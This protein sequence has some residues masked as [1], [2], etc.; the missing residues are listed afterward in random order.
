MI[1]L[2]IATTLAAPSD[3]EGGRVVRCD[4]ADEGAK[5]VVRY[6]RVEL[7]PGRRTAEGYLL[8]EATIAKPGVLR[9]LRAD[10]TVVRELVPP[11]ELHKAD[12][13]ATLGRKPVTL[14]HP[15]EGMVTTDNVGDLAVGDID[16]DVTIANDGYVKIKMAVRRQDALDAIAAGTHEMSP[17]YTCRIDA[18]PGKHPIYGEYDAI[19]RERRYNHSAIVKRAR[20]GETIRL[21]ADSAVAVDTMKP[22]AAPATRPVTLPST[23][24]PML[25]W[26]PLLMLATR[27]DAQ[28]TEVRE[29]LVAGGVAKADAD[30]LLT[31]FDAGRDARTELAR[32]DAEAVKARTD[33]ER[34]EVKAAAAKATFDAHM[35][36]FTERAPLVELAEGFKMDAAEVAK[37]DNAALCKAIALKA[38]PKL[39]QDRAD[40]YYASYV[41]IVRNAPAGNPYARL[42]KALEERE[43]TAPADGKREPR[44]NRFDA[45]FDEQDPHK[46][47]ARA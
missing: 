22:Q 19:Q 35:A 37:L 11:E 38:D 9:Y 5:E 28:T 21:R 29:G 17:G 45:A 33:A 47:S 30:K 36:F 1:L 43:D 12:S 8:C 25:R 18:T 14:E 10:G 27:T 42:G 44:K 13:L 46:R 6:D 20:G 34:P 26:L 23:E 41:D 16:G 40:A 31:D 24:A 7:M 3:D 32:R 15:A 2:A 4:A 39:P